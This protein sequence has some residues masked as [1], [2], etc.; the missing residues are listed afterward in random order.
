MR[1]RHDVHCG[2]IVGRMV[3]DMIEVVL[4][5][6]MVFLV[7]SN[8]CSSRNVV[9]NPSASWRPPF[10]PFAFPSLDHH[11]ACSSVCFALSIPDSHLIHSHHV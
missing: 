6:K 3:K 11:I 1:R 10:G 2:R 7:A 9:R 4:I 5:C 8:K